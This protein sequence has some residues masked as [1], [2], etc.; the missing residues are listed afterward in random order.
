[1]HKLPA[2]KPGEPGKRG[3]RP[4]KNRQNGKLLAG[5]FCDL[6]GKNKEIHK[7][8]PPTLEGNLPCWREILPSLQ[9]NKHFF[10]VCVVYLRGWQ[11]QVLLGKALF[12]LKLISVNNKWIL[13][14]QA[15][16]SR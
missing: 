8:N 1:M 10:Q 16:V 2:G 3:I 5:E 15:V 4:G 11:V 9:A 14:E 12:C 7:G 13:V 6:E